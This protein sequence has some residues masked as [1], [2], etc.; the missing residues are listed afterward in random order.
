[1]YAAY[2]RAHGFRTLTV[3][4][5]R[6]AISVALTERPSVIVMDLSLPH[7]DGWEATRRL[8]HHPWTSDIPIVACSAHVLAGAAEH[9]LE[10]GCDVFLAK[11][12]LPAR[13]L[14]EVRAILRRPPVRR[15]A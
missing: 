6:T 3:G 10:A 12:C 14:D 1:M 5:G 7:V 4:D 13:L 2:F 11:P 15:R 9:A 8:K